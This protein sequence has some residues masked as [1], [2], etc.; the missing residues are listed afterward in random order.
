MKVVKEMLELCRAKREWG[1]SRE[2]QCDASRPWPC[3]LG[4][5]A[6]AYL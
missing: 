5:Y 2:V 4:R 1:M 6:L 3:F